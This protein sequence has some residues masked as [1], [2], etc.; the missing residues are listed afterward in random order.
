MSREE[1]QKKNKPS[2]SYASAHWT[3]LLEHAGILGGAGSW[4]CVQ[5]IYLLTPIS[6]I[7]GT[8]E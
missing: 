6:Y 4:G 8:V 1:R 5:C 2:D 3:L 7:L